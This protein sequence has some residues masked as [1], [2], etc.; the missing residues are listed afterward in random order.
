MKSVQIPLSESYKTEAAC[1]ALKN[2][3]DNAFEGIAK[4]KVTFQF[5]KDETRDLYILDVVFPKRTPEFTLEQ[6]VLIGSIIG[7]N[8]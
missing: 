3:L 5:H 2:K 8:L 4:N 7:Q 6:C 1:W